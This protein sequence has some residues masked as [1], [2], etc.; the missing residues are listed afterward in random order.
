MSKPGFGGA[1]V[2][3]AT[4]FTW[5]KKLRNL[6]IEASELPP[7]I[8]GRIYNDAMDVGFGVYS[9]TG[10]VEYFYLATF[11]KNRE[12]EVT[13]WVFEPVNHKLNGLVSVV[14]FND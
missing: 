6:V 12:G 2:Y 4:Q 7:N 13:S 3:S 8:W 10:K 1:P 14:V 11:N 9:K 5:E